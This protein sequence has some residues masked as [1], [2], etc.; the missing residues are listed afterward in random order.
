MKTRIFIYLIVL[1]IS[2]INKES[3]ALN[4]SSPIATYTIAD[5]LWAD[6][7]DMDGDGYTRSRT[8]CTDVNVNDGAIHSIYLKIYCKIASATS[9]TLYYTTSNYNITGT[10][11][12]DFNFVTIGL[13]N[14]ELDQ[15]T[16]DFKVAAY[17][18]GGTTVVASKDAT[19]DIDLNDQDFETAVQD[20]EIYDC[21]PDVEYIQINGTDV[22]F[23]STVDLTL[24]S[25]NDSFLIRLRGENDGTD[26]APA[27]LSN[28]TISFQQFTS[29]ADKNLITINSSTNSDLTM[30]KYFGSEATGGDGY[31][32]YVMVEGTDNN[33]WDPNESNNIYLNVKPKDWGQFPIEFRMGLPTDNSWANFLHDPNGGYCPSCNESTIGIDPIKF[34]SYWIV[35]NI[36]QPI[37]NYTITTSPNP[38]EGGSTSGDGTYPNGSTCTVTAE[39]NNCYQFV[40]WTENG[41][42]VSNSA[43]YSFTVNGNRNLVAN[44]STINYTI[45]TTSNPLAGGSTSGG[46]TKQCGSTCT[47]TAEPNNCY[48]FVNWTENGNVVSNSAL[49]SFTVNGNR[50]LVANFSTINYTINTTSNPLAGGSTSGGGTKQCGSTCTVTATPNN[51]YQFN[52]WTENGTVVST[53]ASYQ[54]TVNGDRN[55]VA[56]F[57][58]INYTIT[59]SANPTAGGLTNGGGSFACGSTCTLIASPNTC[60]QFVSWT[61]NGNV[62]SNSATYSFTVNSN[63]NLVANFSI[64]SY[65]IT[66]SSNPAAGGLTSGG[67]SFACGSTCTVIATPSTCYEFVNWTE[68]GNVVSTSSTYSFT[69]ISNRN[70]VA[71]FSIISYTITTS[72]NPATGGLTSGGGSFACGSTCTVIATPSTCY[73]FVNWTENG[74]V[75]STSSTYSFTV[76][77]NRNLV[78]NF[79]ILYPTINTSSNPSAGGLTSGCG[80]TPCGSTC[81]V[82][83]TP[84]TCYQFVNWTENGNVVSTSASYCFTLNCNRNLVANFSII[85]Y[86]ITT[87]S[88]P[89]EGG[90]TSGGGIK[91]CG[92][93]C[94]V[95]A[96]PTYLY[97]LTCWTENGVI[98][99]DSLSFTFTVNSD[100]NLVANYISTG[101]DLKLKNNPVTV[102][103]NPFMS[104]TQIVLDLTN[105]AEVTQYLKD[106]VGRTVGIVRYRDIL[107]S[108]KDN[109]RLETG[110][111]SAGIYYLETIIDRVRFVNKL[112][113]T[114]SI[115]Y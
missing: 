63:R 108:G 114:E 30:T 100:R 115:S 18:A 60:Y 87:S 7:I 66:T 16:Y 70:L 105:G 104:S 45:N 106:A 62:V 51:C 68:N 111:L 101:I 19:T 113:K 97:Q 56:N 48:Q 5:C 93:K 17:E 25:L 61:E 79:S 49:Y 88:Y 31:A 23:S 15:N 102:V 34:V 3:K 42:V 77:S 43:L 32:D 35:L 112:I 86:S 96:T 75:V 55:L 20:P 107:S 36:N 67:G 13:P 109:F 82:T 110:N 22:P 72:S 28:L 14:I 37:T 21:I 6:N 52:N 9:Y 38:P 84:N 24:N 40:N 4:V 73:E 98:V 90:T 57:S 78:A 47:V 44:F 11:S 58:I 89:D 94:T 65:T 50:N 76:I 92:L 103:P 54:F 10:S 33:G 99:T 81:C 27:N 83:A 95:T 71:N 41:N 26:M 80:S 59:T 74:N 53:S 2:I 91:D 69:V 64:T 1:V 12:G 8:L 85:Q 29:S 46:G 39:P